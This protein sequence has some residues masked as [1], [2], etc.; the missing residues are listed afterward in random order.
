MKLA[1]ETDLAQRFPEGGNELC[2][3]PSS[4][5]WNADLWNLM[6]CNSFSDDVFAIEVP[7]HAQTIIPFGGGGFGVHEIRLNRGPPQRMRLYSFSKENTW[8]SCRAD[9]VRES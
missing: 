8:T 7:P 6:N 4:L 3:F 5:G 9:K 1:T 2:L